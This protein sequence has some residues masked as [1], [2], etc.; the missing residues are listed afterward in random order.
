MLNWLK[1]FT[2]SLFSDSQAKE[3]VRYGFGGILL[4]SVLALIFLF[5]GVF[6]GK[7]VPFG[8]YY[9]GA[10]DFRGF[11]YNA[12]IGSDTAEPI[13]VTVKDGKAEV[14]SGGKAV[15]INTFTEEDDRQ[16][17]SVNGYQ[18]IVDS[19]E[20]ADIYDDFEA[21]CIDKDGGEEITYE[22]Y[23]KLDAQN[24]KQYRFAVR[25]TGEQKIITD[26][27]A[28]GYADYISASGDDEAKEELKKLQDKR[29]ELTAQE[30][31]DGVY[32]LYVKSYY[33]DVYLVTGENVPTLRTYYYRLTLKS[34]GKY[35][36][37]FGDM[38]IASFESYGGGALTFG[39]YYKDGNNL[40]ANG[41]A[42]GG[43]GAVDKFFKALYYDG[44]SMLFLMELLNS[45]TV[46]VFAELIIVGCMLV[47]YG[48]CKFKKIKL[49]DT[50]GK[51]A[52]L[53]ASYAHVGALLA[54]V[55]AFC[56]GFV[57]KGTA[58]TAVTFGVFALILLVRTV[59]LLL[60]EAK[61][62]PNSAEPEAGGDGD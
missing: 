10:D 32:E 37:L 27:D 12:L 28:A 7:T 48:I 59:I 56:L 14:T 42:E 58:V 62:Q 52:K 3:S 4:S 49:C 50:L 35:L 53:V 16:K 19:R 11:I 39:G 5:L 60:R 57:L 21:Y 9:G 25:Y 30:Y 41:T 13:S 26:A 47:C 55:A 46:I 17:Y 1:R 43:S 31:N 38:V 8:A 22:E 44:L 23:L 34:G 40:F 15:L 20:V 54:A 36:C 2:L 29:G 24:K 51:S 45:I 33:P 18:L 61:A 6:A